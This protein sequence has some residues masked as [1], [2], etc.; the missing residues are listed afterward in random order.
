MKIFHI[1]QVVFVLYIL[2]IGKVVC[3]PEVNVIDLYTESQS[4]EYFVLN[5]DASQA[6]IVSSN[7]PNTYEE[8]SDICNHCI[9]KSFNHNRTIAILR[10]DCLA[11]V[12]RVFRILFSYFHIIR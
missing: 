6:N 3:N 9:S 8:H 2:Y 5:S 12:Q 11:F 1:V 10:S 4:T 7:T